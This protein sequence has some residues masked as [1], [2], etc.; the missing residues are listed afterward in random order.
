M[1]YASPVPSA[2]PV[3]VNI[4]HTI[5]FYCTGSVQYWTVPSGV[6]SINFTVAG[7][8]GGGGSVSTNVGAYASGGGGGSSAIEDIT[9]NNFGAVSNGGIGGS[10]TNFNGQSG[11][12][13]SGSMSVKPGD[14]IAIW[15]GQGG[16]GGMAVTGGWITMST[17]GVGGYGFSYG[18]S[19][20]NYCWPVGGGGWGWW[21]QWGNGGGAGGNSISSSNGGMGKSGS[22]GWVIIKFISQ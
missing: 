21:S 9:T 10:C 19:G 22:D 6:T 8:G 14:K 11:W 16:S 1:A 2:P 12:I 17:G 13:D 3:N 15:V 7:G 4:W 20:W 18:G 5:T